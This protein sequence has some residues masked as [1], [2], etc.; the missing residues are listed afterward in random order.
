MTEQK[1]KDHIFD[2]II[3]KDFDEARNKV[4]DYFGDDEDKALAWFLLIEEEEERSSKT[5]SAKR[6]ESYMKENNISLTATEVQYNITNNLDKEFAMEGTATLST[7]YNYGFSNIEEKDF[8]VKLRPT[9]GSYN[10]EW[11]L[12]LHRQSFEQLFD[13]LMN[14]NSVYMITT[15]RIP[16]SIYK[17]GQ[18]NMAEVRSA[19]W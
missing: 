1:K 12:Y 7:Y 11:Y 10:D 16:S 2:L 8:V 17:E 14:N 15:V 19:R 5:V 4:V 6:L 18:G 13:K 3:S 9:G